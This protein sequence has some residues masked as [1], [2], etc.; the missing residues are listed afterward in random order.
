[1]HAWVRFATGVGQD[2]QLVV[3]ICGITN[4]REDDLAGTDAGKDEA[5]R[6]P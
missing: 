1:M 4:R 2:E 6:R 3:P 5:G